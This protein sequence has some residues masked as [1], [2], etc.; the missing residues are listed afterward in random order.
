M[1]QLRALKYFVEV[2][3]A[4]SFT[5]AAK[6]FSVPPSS[7]SR[8]VADLEE[9]LG[10]TLLKRT[11][12]EVK[13]TEV[14]QSYYEQV[15]SILLDLDECNEAVSNYQSKPMGQLKISAMTGFG[16]TILLPLMDEFNE[17]Y[18]DVVLDITL[19]DAVS[20]LSR[21]DVDLAIRGGY[22]PN[23]RV[24]AIELLNNNFIPVASPAYLASEGMPKH[25]LEL[26]DHKGLYYRTPVGPTPWICTLDGQ[27]KNVSA[28][29][30]AVSN[31]GKWL[32][33]KAIKGQGILMVPRWVLRPYLEDGSL[34]ELDIEPPL[35][36]TDNPD[37][38][39]Y[40]LYQKQ[41]YSVP[42]IKAAV[43]FLVD[44]V[45]ANS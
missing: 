30:V 1:D 12:R 11:T 44:R 4:G 39:V 25:P 40:L 36:I 38:A 34:I 2:V 15:R 6:Q 33:R 29:A 7:L 32:V 42:K 19:S 13:L 3:K 14:G 31:E 5:K 43:D 17:L 23:E 37:F 26:R 10:A 45:K 41:R 22:A 35:N 18:P 8:R 9:S 21:D 20:T 24:V 27:R 28:P 16:E